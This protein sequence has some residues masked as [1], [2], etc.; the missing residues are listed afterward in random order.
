V[1]FHYSLHFLP[2]LAIASLV[3]LAVRRPSER[4]RSVFGLALGTLIVTVHFGAFFRPTFS[5]AFHKVSFGWTEEDD[6]RRDAWRRIASKVADD[7]AVSAGEHEGPHLARRRHLY[8]LK[9]GVK[10]ARFVVFS[11]SSLRWGGAEHVERAL[12]S[13]RFGIVAIEGPFVVLERGAEETGEAALDE[14][15]KQKRL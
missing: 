12:Q 1:Q 15:R 7:A 3:A 14:L 4:L 13:N 5:T 6:K 10:D 11:R 8:A 2:Y 9:D